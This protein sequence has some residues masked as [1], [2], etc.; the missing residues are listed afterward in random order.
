[1]LTFV[2]IEED[3]SIEV[4]FDEDGASELVAI[5]DDLSKGGP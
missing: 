5:V 4:L 3:C 2:V 1:M